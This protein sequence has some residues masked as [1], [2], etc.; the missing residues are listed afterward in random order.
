MWTNVHV[1]YAEK[2][3]HS[4]SS[5]II[6]FDAS[7]NA[8]VQNISTLLAD[9]PLSRINSFTTLIQGLEFYGKKLIILRDFSVFEFSL[10]LIYDG[11]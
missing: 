1:K 9:A 7:S 11:R 6:N 8:I 4:F 5:P 10:S 2:R 3:L